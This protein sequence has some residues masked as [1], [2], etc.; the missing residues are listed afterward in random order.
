MGSC[1]ALDQRGVE[2]GNGDC[3]SMAAKQ[4]LRTSLSLGRVPR[5]RSIGLMAISMLYIG[6]G[7]GGVLLAKMNL[8]SITNLVLPA[9]MASRFQIIPRAIGPTDEHSAEHT[10]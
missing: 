4:S 9:H 1:I 8:V 10:L 6:S 7:G 3:T 5:L 2:S